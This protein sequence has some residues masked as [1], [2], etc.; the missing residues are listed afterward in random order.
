ML[1]S[2][3]S[4]KEVCESIGNSQIT[5]FLDFDKTSLAELIGCFAVEYGNTSK[6]E[7]AKQSTQS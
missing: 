7:H 5:S 3:F 2:A 1:L 4:K 6:A